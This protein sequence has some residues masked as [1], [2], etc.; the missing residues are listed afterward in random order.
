MYFINSSC[1]CLTNNIPQCKALLIIIGYDSSIDTFLICCV[2][3]LSHE[4]KD[5]LTELYSCLKNIWNFNPKKITLD[6]ALVNIN[7]IKKVFEG[8]NAS[9]L[10]CF[11]T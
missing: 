11:F 7:A 5:T 1:K 2:V 3:L 6:F 10:P 9:I 4:D 8:I